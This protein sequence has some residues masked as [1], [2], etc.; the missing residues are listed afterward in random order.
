M[1]VQIDVSRVEQLTA[2]AVP[3]WIRGVWQRTAIRAEDAAADRT[4]TV[5]WI[6]TPTLYADIRVPAPGETS[7]LAGEAGFAGW[8]DVDGQVCRWRRP[9]DLHPGPEGADQGAMFR[10]GELLVEVGL[11]ANYHEEYRLIDPPTRSFAASRGGFMIENGSVR[12]APDGP[13]DIL[14]A[15]GPY[16]THARRGGTSALRHGRLEDGGVTFDLAVGDPAVFAGG[17]GTWTV[18]TD[19]IGETER[20]AL[21][22]AT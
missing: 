17:Q 20:A 18:W 7:A 14:V 5:I 22:A 11:L 16:V 4:S 15:A 8:L 10:D 6:Q 9:I 2:L 3:E 1:S 19:E 13:L 21:L 12:F